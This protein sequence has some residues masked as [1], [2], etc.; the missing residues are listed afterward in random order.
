VNHFCPLVDQSN[1]KL[2]HKIIL[3]ILIAFYSNR[4]AAFEIL[5]PRTEACHEYLSLATLG[6]GPFSSLTPVENLSGFFKDLAREA[7]VG[8]PQDSATL[9]L[10]QEHRRRFGLDGLSLDELFIVT[11]FLVGTREPDSKGFSSVDVNE[12]R[13]IHARDDQQSDHALR[14]LSHDGEQ[15]NQDAIAESRSRVESLAQDYRACFS[16]NGSLLIQTRWTFPFY[17]ERDVQVHCPAYRLGLIAHLIQDAYAHFL[18]DSLGSVVA[19][20]N[21]I[22]VISEGLIESRDG[23]PH[24]DRLDRCFLEDSFDRARLSDATTATVSV[25]QSISQPAEFAAALESIFRFRRGCD[26]SNLYCESEWYRVALEDLSSALNF[27]S[28]AS[29]SGRF[30]QR[31]DDG[32][33]GNV[34]LSQFF[35]EL[36]FIVP[37]FIIGVIWWILRFRRAGCLLAFVSCAVGGF[38][39]SVVYASERVGESESLGNWLFDVQIRPALSAAVDRDGLWILGGGV[40]L[41]LLAFKFDEAVRERIKSDRPLDGSLVRA[42]SFLGSG[43]PGIFISAVQLA[44]DHEEGIAHSRALALTSIN[45]ITLALATQRGRPG[46][47]DQ[48]SFPSGHVASAFASATSLSYSYGPRIGIPMFA[49]AT[50]VAISRLSD[51][52]HWLSDCVA[53][54]VLGFYWG[55]ASAKAPGI[56]RWPKAIGSQI[57]FDID[58]WI[59]SNGSGLVAHMK[60]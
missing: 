31:D 11:S 16:Q 44:Y 38:S 20:S 9:G 25:I 24:S 17:G 49:V 54:A 12:L 51:D 53:G 41:T 36:G 29:V 1:L 30:S 7:K 32:K 52:V 43:G 37:S 46:G 45:H 28:C 48:V 2:W 13:S 10:M 33:H 6:I 40:G 21:Y 5:S 57:F 18:R 34:R 59:S 15:G 39:T 19:V 4:A 26:V 27:S 58:P 35:S 22:E 47:G 50:L 42:G 8:I 23:P 60:F 56:N 14:R 55:R 3:F